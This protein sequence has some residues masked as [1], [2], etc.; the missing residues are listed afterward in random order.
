MARIVW[1]STA[2]ST[3]AT[4]A[5]KPRVTAPGVGVI[6]GRPA[7]LFVGS[8]GSLCISIRS[9][10]IVAINLFS[11]SLSYHDQLRKMV[12]E[13]CVSARS[14]R[15][16]PRIADTARRLFAERG[17]EAVTVAEVARAAGVGRRRPSSMTSKTRRS[18]STAASR[19]SRSGQ[20]LSAVRERA[21]GQSYP[22][23]PC[24][25]LDGRSEAYS[26][27]RRSRRRRG[28]RPSQLRDRSL[29]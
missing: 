25:A 21:P 29:A 3:R 10:T 9:L 13:A 14:S 28:R 20:L 15:R 7:R 2:G 6:G 22:R 11:S 8:L 16:A 5:T 27:I 17:F 1:S 18:S 24:A 26:R 23:P 4:I 12:Y 19:R